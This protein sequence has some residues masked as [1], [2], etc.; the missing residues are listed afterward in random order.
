MLSRFVERRAEERLP[1]KVMFGELVG[2]KGYSK[3]PNKNLLVHLKEVISAITIKLQWWRKISQ[4]AGM[5]F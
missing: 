1:Q 4:K 2:G 3:G 5:W